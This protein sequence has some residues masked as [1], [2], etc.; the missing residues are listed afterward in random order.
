VCV[1]GI[2][3]IK[4]PEFLIRNSGLKAATEWRAK[5]PQRFDQHHKRFCA[6][7]AD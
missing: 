1:S 3:A 5:S 4:S 2:E 7:R 6:D